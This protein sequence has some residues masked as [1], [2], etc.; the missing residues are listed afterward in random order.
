MP[1]E[2]V[3]HF[4]TSDILLFSGITELAGITPSE[5]ANNNLQKHVNPGVCCFPLFVKFGLSVYLV[6]CP[7]NVGPSHQST[8]CS[9]GFGIIC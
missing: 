8:D 4:I 6:D 1:F 3:S 9:P 5:V 7:V 2:V